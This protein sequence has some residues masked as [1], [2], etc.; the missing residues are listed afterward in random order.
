[1][2]DKVNRRMIVPHLPLRF[3]LGLVSFAYI[4]SAIIMRHPEANPSPRLEYTEQKQFNYSCI[5]RMVLTN[6]PVL[7]S[8]EL[9][10]VLPLPHCKA[11]LFV[12]QSGLRVKR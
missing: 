8:Y 5:A 1:M 6:V 10:V 7:H 3:I 4:I 2:A 12:C 11:N 9:W